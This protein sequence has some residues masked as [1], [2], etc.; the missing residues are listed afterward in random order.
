MCQHG[1]MDIW[2]DWFRKIPEKCLSNVNKQ[3]PTTSKRDKAAT[4]SFR[5]L[6]GAFVVLITVYCLALFA[7][8]KER[9]SYRMQSGN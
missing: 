4:I 8:A 7:F 9:I 1:F 5:N 6:T 2:E 3:G